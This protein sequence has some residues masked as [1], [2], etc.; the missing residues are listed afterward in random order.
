MIEEVFTFISTINHTNGKLSDE[1]VQHALR[2]INR[3]IREDFELYCARIIP[4][5]S[6]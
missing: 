4:S 3:Q 2:A 6:I 5:A 1:D